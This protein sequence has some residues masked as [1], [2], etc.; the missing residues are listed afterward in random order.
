VLWL[1]SDGITQINYVY[2]TS[3]TVGISSITTRRTSDLITKVTSDVFERLGVRVNDGITQIM[4]AYRTIDKVHTSSIR[5]HRTSYLTANIK[6]DVSAPYANVRHTR[7][8]IDH[9][10]DVEGRISIAYVDFTSKVRL[11]GAKSRQT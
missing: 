6:D 3:D 10:V 8:T 11:R 4:D 2:R 1:L 7:R 5:I 9:T